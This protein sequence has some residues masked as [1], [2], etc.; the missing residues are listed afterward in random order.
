MNIE[1]IG[2]FFSI[3]LVAT[4]TPGPAI[5]LVSANSVSYGVRKSILTILGNITGLFLMSLLAIL[6]LS[7]IILNSASIFFVVK[8]VGALYLIYLGIKLWRK[9]FSLTSS[10][11]AKEEGL[12]SSPSVYQFYF[13][14]L[15]IALSNPKAIAFTTAL[16][17]QFIDSSLSLAPQFFVLVLIF[18]TLSF[19]CLLAYAVLA[20]KAK[21]HSN[22]Q[23]L[24]KVLS[25]VFALVFIGSGM[26][27]VFVRQK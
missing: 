14:G 24:P 13:Q 6:G 5:I 12:K 11:R 7:T 22:D 16:F 1:N 26:A 3:A 17:P 27:L 10:V 25:K 15:L 2:L 18:M 20:V 4:I 19:L 21:N 9:G 23:R 8:I